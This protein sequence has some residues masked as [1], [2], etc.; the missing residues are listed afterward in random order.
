MN[1]NPKQL[2]TILIHAALWIIYISYEA[3]LLLFSNA[4]HFSFVEMG[5][6]FVVYALLFYT[7]GSL[8]LPWLYRRRQ[9]LLFGLLLLL[10]FTGYGLLRYA[11]N[12]YVL[13]ALGVHMLRPIGPMKLFWAQTISRGIYFLMLSFVYWFSSNAVQ[14]EK[15]K[16]KQEKRLRIAEKNLFEAE[17]ISLKS[18]INP[19]FLF[20][21]LNM[22]YS[23]VYPLSERTAQGILLL[24]NIMHYSLKETEEN[25]KVMLE[26]EVHHLQNYVEINQLRFSNRLQIEF[27]IVGNHQFFMIVPLVLITFVENCFKHGEL[28]D[29]QAP[30]LIRLNLLENRL[31]LYTHNKKRHGPKEKTTGIGLAN[32]RKRLDAFYPGLYSLHVSNEA[33][34][35]TCNLHINL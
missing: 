32:T 22:L 26:E 31:Q 35:Y 11:I 19:H 15:E 4:G 10:M 1:V 9:Y 34:Y 13:P 33:E 30:L 27:E 23:Q 7:N 28:F 14:L 8:L 16:R 29:P 17:L 21:A 3:F 20:N 5:S 2:K 24:S 12:S 25:G 6:N 18:Q